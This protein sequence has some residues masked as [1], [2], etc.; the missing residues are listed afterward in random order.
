[1]KIGGKRPPSFSWGIADFLLCYFKNTVEAMKF[2]E[3]FGF[4]IKMYKWE[5]LI[6]DFSCE[7]NPNLDQVMIKKSIASVMRRDIWVMTLA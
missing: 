6:K 2:F 1:M 5:E 7:K 4:K 3:S